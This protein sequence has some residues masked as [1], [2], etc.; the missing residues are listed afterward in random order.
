MVERPTPGGPALDE[1][2]IAGRR[3][4]RI[5][6][7]ATVRACLFD[8][9][10]VIADTARLH[11]AAWKQM[12]D[13][14]LRSRPEPFVPFDLRRDYSAYV[15]GRERNEGVR[16]FLH[17][18]AVELPEGDRDDAPAVDSVYGLGNRKNVLAL[19]LIR[20]SDSLVF[21]DARRFLEAVRHAGLATAVVSSSANCG[22]VLAAGRITDLFDVRIDANVA[23]ERRL[24]GKPAPDMYCAAAAALDV[25][26]SSAAVFEDALVGVAAGH[27]GGFF[28]VVGIAR[29]AAD[30]E[31]RSQGADLVVH[32]LDELLELP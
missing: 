22:S 10:G 3:S 13:A 31:L 9:D 28:P 17:A 25:A 4:P 12:F 21:G 2:L 32:D 14:F 5:R 27:A 8:L 18:R 20:S 1:L 23:V 7:P 15:D 19:E 11:A 29:T 30:S 16:C 6:L 26:P 24:R